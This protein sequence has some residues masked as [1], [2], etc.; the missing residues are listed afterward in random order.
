M[1]DAAARVQTPTTKVAPNVDVDGHVALPVRIVMPVVGLTAR[2]V[3][4]ARAADGSIEV[5]LTNSAGWYRLGPAPGAVGPAVLVGHVDWK[6]GPA[7]FYPLGSVRVGDVGS[8][9]R[10]DG[11]VAQFRVYAVT[12][13]RKS[14]F[15]DSAVFAPT[16]TPELRLVTCTGVFLEARHHYADSLIVWAT[17]TG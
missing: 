4:V 2:V 15:P 5:P 7:V 9:I 10:A 12:V 17:F 8:I 6:V 14:T 16:G 11:T 1:R 13:A 3:S